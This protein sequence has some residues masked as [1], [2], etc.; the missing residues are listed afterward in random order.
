MPKPLSRIQ[1][2][3]VRLPMPPDPA[4]AASAP[5]RPQS[6]G[7]GRPEKLKKPGERLPPVRQ[8]DERDVDGEQEQEHHAEHRPGEVLEHPLDGAAERQDQHD[9][10][11]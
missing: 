4:V 7:C 11:G 8:R 5:I 1:L 3:T 6:I 2:V 10:R 9:G